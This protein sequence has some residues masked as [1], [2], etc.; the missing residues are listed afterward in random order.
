[1]VV[2][3]AIVLGLSDAMAGPLTVNALAEEEA[4]LVFCTVTDCGP[5]E[6]S[7]VLVTAAVSEVA[8]P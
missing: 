3:A 4:A 7:W 6:A 5:A 1:V 8:P 2:P